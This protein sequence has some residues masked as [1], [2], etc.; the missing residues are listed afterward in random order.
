M[1]RNS[2]AGASNSNLGAEQLRVRMSSKSLEKN[3]TWSGDYSY[4]DYSRRDIHS[5]LNHVAGKYSPE[6]LSF[7][8]PRKGI[9]KVTRQTKSADS[10]SPRNI[11]ATA[12]TTIV[13]EDSGRRDRYGTT[14]RDGSKLHRISFAEQLCEVREFESAKKKASSLRGARFGGYKPGDC[15]CALI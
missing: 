13:E 12:S 7:C 14:I 10:G 15:I 5:T 11:D 9:L 3:A 8:I 6:T 1:G 2:R 4:L